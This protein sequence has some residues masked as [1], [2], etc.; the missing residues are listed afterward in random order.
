M[1]PVTRLFDILDLFRDEYSHKQH[2][3][4][5]RSAG[6]WQA[7]SSSEYVRLS[8]ELSLGLLELGVLPGTRIATVMAN[9]PEWNLFDMAIS[10]AGAIQVPIYPTISEENYFYIFTDAK[11]EYLVIYHQENYNRIKNVLKEL[12]PLK[13]MFSIQKVRGVPLWTDLLET[14]RL[15]SGS[16]QLER[17]KEG[18]RPDDIASIIYTSGTTGRPKGVMLSHG[19]FVSNFKE[20]A[21]ISDFTCREKALSFLPLCH[22]Y[23]RM[24]NYVYQYLGMSIYYAT[25]LEQV[26]EY[27]KEVRPHTFAAVPRV[28]EKIYNKVVAEG[29]NLHGI[30]RRVFFW[31]L[32]QGQT[33][34][35]NR[36]NGWFY[37]VKLLIAN[38][39]V[40]DRWRKA[41][42]GNVRLIACGGASLH[43]ML[44]RIYW[45]ARLKVLEGYGLT[46]TAPVIAV[47][48]LKPGGVKFGTVGPVL[49]GVQVTFAP[50]GEILCK[51]P[52]L[53]KGYVN[54]PE[55]TREVIDADGWF[56]TGDIGVMIEGK[57][58]QITD[59]KKEIFKTS[60]GKY[61]APQ[62]IEQRFVESP[63]IDY[64][65]VLGEDRKYAAALIV[66]NFD[67]LKSWCRVKRIPYTSN[68]EA[69]SDNHILRRMHQEVN[70][71]NHELGQTEKIKKFRLLADEWT[72]ESGELSPTMKLRRKFIQEKYF[73][74][75]EE[76]YR[77]PEYNYKEG[78]LD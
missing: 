37:E 14:G 67:H 62:P 41:L 68:K 76:T 56:H 58:L 39:L 22:V 63:F 30:R 24:L 61:I 6:K 77:S 47:Q 65:L 29:R 60:T 7:I 40:F 38:L 75:I 5:S 23:E 54:R 16:E 32:R 28:L 13:G 73:L 17:V 2:L 66:P 3:F 26:P 42:G 43:P 52:N 31:A 48:N 34:E 36:S 59:R 8:H 70:Q 55:K 64:I 53:M 45:A 35:L 57:Y 46:E 72:V 1:K 18:I 10:Q 44:A 49:P 71:I 12:P 11:V 9:C 21:S 74:E 19:N 33:F 50:D 4:L 78:P 51:G 15:S 69:I 20:C 25:A 27:L